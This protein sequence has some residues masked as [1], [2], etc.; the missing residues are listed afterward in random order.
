MTTKA[1]SP[2][3]SKYKL[4]FNQSVRIIRGFEKSELHQ[5]FS[6]I[7]HDQPLQKSHHMLYW[8]PES[9]TN[10]GVSDNSA[11]GKHLST[12]ML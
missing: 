2:H 6:C 8:K 4:F 5:G 10:L 7:I 9:L 1:V 12:P 3:D 11:L